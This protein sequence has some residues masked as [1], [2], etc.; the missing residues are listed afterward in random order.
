[1]AVERISQG[2]TARLEQVKPVL[3]IFRRKSEGIFFQVVIHLI[4]IDVA[5]TFLMPVL[6]MVTKSFMSVQ[7][8]I[9]PAIRWIPTQVNY[10]NYYLAYLGVQYPLGLRN[11]TIITLA[12]AIGQLVSCALVGYGFARG[13]FPGRDLLFLLVLFTFIVP[14]ETIIVPLFILFKKLHWID[15]FYPFIIPSFFAQGLRGPI[16]VLLFRQFFKGQPWELEEAARIDGCGHL[17]I[18]FRIMLPMARPAILVT[19]LFSVVWH[20]NEWYQPGIFLMKQDHFTVP[21]MYNI[22]QD[23]LNQLT[24]GHAG[25]FVNLPLIMAASMLVVL[26][27]LV[28]YAFTQRFFVQSI[29]RTGLVE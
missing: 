18:F 28:L 12:S 16:F 10:L 4:L 24:G 25:E 29:E 17:R 19:F 22:L 7:D 5:F 15:S 14:P 13:K 27:P 3:H 20:W 1:M 21:L 2:A 9:D 8:S 6:F 26:P 23:T 11:S